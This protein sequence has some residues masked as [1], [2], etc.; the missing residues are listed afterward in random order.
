MLVYKCE[1]ESLYFYDAML[2]NEKVLS[3]KQNILSRKKLLCRSGASELLNTVPAFNK[4]A[5]KYRFLES[6]IT[7]V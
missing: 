4:G 1:I 3:T 6:D 2:V 5:N 7:K